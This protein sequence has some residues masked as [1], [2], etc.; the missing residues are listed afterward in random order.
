[1]SFKNFL[2]IL[3]LSSC[4]LVAG[5]ASAQVYDGYTPLATSA[6]YVQSDG[7][8]NISGFIESAFQI[9]IS[10]AAA[11]SVIFIMIGG[12]QYVTT[13]AYS[14]KSDAR[15]TI[16]NAIF[17]L[18][19]AIGAYA[20]LYTINPALVNFQI[21]IA[22]RESGGAIDPTGLSG[23]LA[24]TTSGGV[25]I[26]SPDARAAGCIVDCVSI[27][28]SG[29]TLKPSLQCA[30]RGCFLNFKLVNAL[31][32][33]KK[34]T[35]PLNITWQVTEAIPQT[36]PHRSDCHKSN[37]SESGRCVD[38][39]LISNTPANIATMILEMRKLNLVPTYEACPDSERDRLRQTP[40]LRNLVGNIQCYSTTTGQHF[41]IVLS[42][43]V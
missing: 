37:L 39:G 22:G 7:T 14:G 16:E 19:M 18:I 42:P 26:G 36:V 10:I 3:I 28:N 4:F 40:E 8:V 11:L 43:N 1:M 31:Q 17:G 35:D 12:L 2:T 24:T 27:T 38:L 23:G 13:E 34:I 15:K 32:D 5:S 41:H 21:G 6:P 9:G 25:T 20:I 30:T 33:L 29:L